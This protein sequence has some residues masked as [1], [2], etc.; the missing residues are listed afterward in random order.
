MGDIERTDKNKNFEKA[1]D[2]YYKVCIL[3][4]DKS[5]VYFKI[6]FCYE[7][8]KNYDE[9]ITNY[10]KT[11]RR[12]PK[13]F[14][15]HKNLAMCYLRFGDRNR[16]LAS[17][18]DAHKLNNKDIEIILKLAD[19]YSKDETKLAEAESFIRKALALNPDLPETIVSLGKL[20]EKQGKYD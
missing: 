4:P 8:I 11:I 20:Y 5:D 15:A 3:N 1:L 18:L 16:G 10:K 19:I 12:N 6:G 14:I 13:N 2:Y 7:K 9:A 17:L